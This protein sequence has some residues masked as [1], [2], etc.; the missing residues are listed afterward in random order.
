MCY[1]IYDSEELVQKR[2]VRA[3]NVRLKRL[4][5]TKE[6]TAERLRKVREAAALKKAAEAT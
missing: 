3:D 1:S 5:E 2:K 4:Q 6:E